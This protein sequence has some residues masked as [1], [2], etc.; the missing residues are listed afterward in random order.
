MPSVDTHRSAAQREKTQSK[1][2]RG[3]EGGLWHVH[4]VDLSIAWLLAVTAKILEAPID[5]Q[6]DNDKTN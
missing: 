1:G 6:A 2:M 5:Q 3:G 4:N